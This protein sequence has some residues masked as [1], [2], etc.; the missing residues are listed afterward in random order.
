VSIELYSIQIPTQE[1]TH[2]CSVTYCCNVSVQLQVRV[3]SANVRPEVWAAKNKTCIVLTLL[4]KGTLW[5]VGCLTFQA[6]I[7]S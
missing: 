5:L 2:F 3:G 4:S 1:E 7:R 6:L